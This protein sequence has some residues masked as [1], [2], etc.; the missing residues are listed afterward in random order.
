MKIILVVLFAIFIHKYSYCQKRKSN[1]LL[2]GYAYLNKSDSVKKRVSSIIGKNEFNFCN[3][4]GTLLYVCPNVHFINLSEYKEQLMPYC[5]SLG[6]DKQ[7]LNNWLSYKKKHFFESYQDSSLCKLNK[8]KNKR[9]CTYVTFS[10]VVGNVL[11]LRIFVNEN[12]GT[13]NPCNLLQSIKFGKVL[14]VILTF[15]ASFSKV[16]KAFFEEVALN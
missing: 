3:T 9:F 10:K 7:E 5:D 11:P 8:H 13:Q 16:E 6:L 12:T 2:I 4:N 15:D 1:P 14:V